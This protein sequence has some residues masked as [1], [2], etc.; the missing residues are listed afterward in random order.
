MRNKSPNRRQVPGT[1]KKRERDQNRL[2]LRRIL[3]PFKASA[4][5]PK[6]LRPTTNPEVLSKPREVQARLA[7]DA[8]VAVAGEEAAADANRQSRKHSLRP[9]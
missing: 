1:S 3:H 6:N 2:Q 9:R 7:V 8:A 5:S 4:L